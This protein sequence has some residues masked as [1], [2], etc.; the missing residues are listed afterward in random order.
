MMNIRRMSVNTRFLNLVLLICVGL[1]VSLA[2]ANE[3]S[4]SPQGAG[5]KSKVILLGFDGVDFD[6]ASRFM[7]EGY[8][9]HLQELREKGT[10]VPLTTANP[11]QSPVAWASIVTGTNPG[12]TNIGGFIKRRF[13]GKSVIPD[14]VTIEERYE[15]ETHQ[16]PFSEVSWLSNDSKGQWIAVF[17]GIFLVLG[18]LILKFLLRLGFVFSLIGGVVLGVVAVFFGFSFFKELPDNVPFPYN[19]QQGESFWEL[20]SRNQVKTVGLYAPGAYPVVAPAEANILGGL[21]NPDVAGGTGTWYIY[22]SEILTFF[23]RGTNTGGKVF[24]L[25]EEGDGRLYGRLY[26]PSNFYRTEDFKKQIDALKTRAADVKLTAEEKDL[27]QK[28]L[29]AKEAEFASFKGDDD[30]KKANLRFTIT[31]DYGNKSMV[32]EVDGQSQNIKEGEWSD[33]FKV[34]FKISEYLKVPA[35]VRLRLIMC[36]DEQVR[37]FVPAIDISPES[38]PPYLRISS[39]ADYSTNLAQNLGG[40]YETVGWACITHGLKDEEISEEVFMEDVE[41][42]MKSRRRLMRNQMERNDWDLFF[43]TYY[44]TD[45]VQHMMY[46]LFDPGHPQYNPELA[47][48]EVPFFKGELFKQNI[49]LK[50]SILK[51]YEV[52]DSII[53]EVLRRMKQG[54]FGKDPLLMIVSDHGFAPFYYCMGVNNFL[55]E[56]NFMALPLDAQG[57]PQT[58]QAMVDQDRDDLLTFVDWSRT[59]AY[60]LGL[61]KIFINLKG[62]EPRGIV[63][64]GEEYEKV[65]NDIIREMEAY[66]DPRTGERVVNRVFK[67]EEIFSGNFWKEGDTEFTFYRPDGEKFTE[68]R[69]TEGF[70]DLYIGFKRKYRVSWQTSLGGLEESIIVDNEQK[71]SGDHVSVDP[72]LVPGVF[73]SNKALKEEWNPSLNDIV[74]T[75]LSFYG[76]KVPEFIDGRPIPL[77]AE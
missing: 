61:G 45:R 76:V 7:D 71:W 20:L 66:V 10:F 48:K 64:P 62:R 65:R 37:F 53:G 34:D 26:G 15:G 2:F 27:A 46:R 8:L 74:P 72:A 77:D 55:I 23:D 29:E 31:P 41:Y 13:A 16:V 73:M 75:L 11:A 6:L 22:S 54:E 51:T 24:R 1:G 50:E 43:E 19:M 28:E 56:K 12:K 38:P 4:S 52:M 49:K 14:L 3:A 57:Q 9:T 44:T 42:T 40:P 60:S 63:E 30:E 35:L 39:P 17:S 47:E 36:A 21:G 32:F 70:A 33:W 59:K 69:Y 58:V 67:R 25:N 18:I 68:E 5:D